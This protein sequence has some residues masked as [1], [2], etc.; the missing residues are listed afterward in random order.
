V[1]KHG[2]PL[3]EFFIWGD[4]TE[5][6]L[7]LASDCPGFL[8]GNSVVLHLRASPAPLDLATEPSLERIAMYKNF[9][10]NHF[11]I[12]RS[13]K[14]GFFNR[15]RVTWRY[16]LLGRTLLRAHNHRLR[17]LRIFLTGFWRGLWFFP[18]VDHLDP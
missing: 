3:K 17:R 5:Y 2:L 15:A 14:K 16:A 11:Y 7:R 9:V 8:I 6:T 10:R 13:G 1:A 18:R 12:A 4:D